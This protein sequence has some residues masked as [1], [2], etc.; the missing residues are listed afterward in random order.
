MKNVLFLAILGLLSLSFCLQPQP[1]NATE[2]RSDSY[3]I[4]FGN[5]NV[6]SGEK[7]SASYNVTDTVGQ[8]GAG[9]YGEYGSSTWFVGGGFQYIYQID[10]F[11]F[12]ISDLIINLGSIIFGVHNSADNTLT[13]TTKGAGGYIIYAYEAHPLKIQSGSTTL[14]D[15]TCDAGTCTETTAQVWSNQSIPGFGFNM[16]GDDVPADFVDTTYF[17]QFADISAAE[18]AQ[19]VMSSTDIADSRQSTVTYKVG[20]PATQAAGNYET[21][22]V[23]IAVPGY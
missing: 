20:M 17:R 22:V 19:V 9:P 1:A 15:T 21:H 16:S 4:Q 5:L 13:I 11:S 18:T 8:L 23:Y 2:M 12:V 10:E 3:W 14:P 7:S 6:T